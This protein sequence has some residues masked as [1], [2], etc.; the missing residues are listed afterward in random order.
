[1]KIT[2]KRT[3]QI[4]LGGVKIGGGAPVVVQSMTNTDTRDVKATVGQINRLAKAGCE[5][6]RVAVLNKEAAA[7]LDKIKKGISIPIIADI[8][9]DHRLALTAIDKGIDGLRI[10][11]GNIGD[12][13]KVAEL[14]KAAKA[15][16]IPIRIGV[17]S[18]S[19]GEAPP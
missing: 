3:K 15:R 18:G 2:R 9:F 12:K 17:N 19:L 13:K 16:H 6:V 4:T 5:V 8:H 11:P 10:N 7:A 1:M 14:V